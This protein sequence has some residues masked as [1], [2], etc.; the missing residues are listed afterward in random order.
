[1]LRVLGTTK[2]FTIAVT[3]N[4]AA[5]TGGHIHTGATGING[6]VIFTFSSLTSPISFTSNALTPAQE[7]ELFGNLNYVNLHSATFPGG[8]IRGQL[9]KGATTGGNGSGGGGGY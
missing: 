8:E 6:P 2:V 9:I 3:H 5:L 7:A 1:M 4:I